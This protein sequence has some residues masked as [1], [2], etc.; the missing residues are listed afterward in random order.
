MEPESLDYHL[1]LPIFFEGIRE[2]KEP[3]KVY[4]IKYINICKK[5]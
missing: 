5:I 3:Y 2:T 1:Y 4:L